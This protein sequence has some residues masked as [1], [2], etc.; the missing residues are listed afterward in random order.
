MLIYN[1]IEIKPELLIPC[2]NIVLKFFFFFFFVFFFF[3]FFFFFVYICKTKCGICIIIKYLSEDT[4]A[5]PLSRSLPEAQNE[6][7]HENKPI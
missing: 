5:M 6:R 4:Q 2:R 3:V 1:V 7:Y